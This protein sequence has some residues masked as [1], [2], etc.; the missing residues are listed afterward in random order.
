[1]EMFGGYA[2]WRSDLK[3]VIRLSADRESPV[4]FRRQLEL[5]KDHFLQALRMGV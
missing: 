5:D 4:C 3:H 2:V 1:M